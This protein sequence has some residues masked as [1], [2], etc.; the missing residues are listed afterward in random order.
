MERPPLGPLPAGFHSRSRG[1]GASLRVGLEVLVSRPPSDLDMFV[2]L[3]QLDFDDMEDWRQYQDIQ[4]GIRS[5]FRPFQPRISYQ[6]WS[7][8]QD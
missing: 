4:Q 5:L 3:E 6:V 1:H 7:S 2:K 8:I